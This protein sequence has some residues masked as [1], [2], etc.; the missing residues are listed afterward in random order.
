MS[1]GVGVATMN[2]RRGAAG[3]QSERSPIQRQHHPSQAPARKSTLVG[4]IKVPANTCK[5]QGPSRDQASREW[6]E[7]NG[8]NKYAKPDCD[9][10]PGDLG[11][12]VARGIGAVA[13]SH[14]T[15]V[16]SQ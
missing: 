8:M 15:S 9:D 16:S 12:S 10:G 14:T 7:A 5:D 3:Q 2:P 11:V 6:T 1:D 13:K 4:S